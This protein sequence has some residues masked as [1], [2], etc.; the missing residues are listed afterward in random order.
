VTTVEG[1]ASEGL[2]PELIFGPLAALTIAG[3]AGVA[4][5]PVLLVDAPLALIALS[6][7]FR[8]L[9][10]IAPLVDPVAF[11][12][13]APLRL[14]L[15]DPFMYALGK[16]FG[17]R[18]LGWVEARSV[19]MGRF[20]SWVERVFARTGALVFLV[21]QGLTVCTV[22]GVFRMHRGWFVAVNLVGTLVHVVIAKYVGDAFADWIWRFQGWVGSHLL[23][24]TTGT[25]VL[26]FIGWLAWRR[27]A[28]S[29]LQAM[30]IPP[31]R[32]GRAEWP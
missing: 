20:V 6:P 24:L 21:N 10:V 16:R 30:E 31:E 23:S 7:L 13:I 9:V 29:R 17:R 14:F 28:R 26:A 22:A 2:R 32:P 15:P 27:Q 18:A 12:V 8:H 4:F 3:F 1:S 5:S 25:A 11:F 19:L